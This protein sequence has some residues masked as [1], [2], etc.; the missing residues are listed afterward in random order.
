[1]FH[2]DY[3]G[4]AKVK[5]TFNLEEPTVMVV[6]FGETLGKTKKRKEFEALLCLPSTV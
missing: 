1:M 2:R 3:Y 4:T 5:M 6:T